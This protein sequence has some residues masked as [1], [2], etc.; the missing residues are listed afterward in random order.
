VGS[1]DP[2]SHSGVH[3]GEQK[4]PTK[5]LDFLF[6]GLQASPVAVFFSFFNFWYGSGSSIFSYGG[7]GFRIPDLDSGFDDL[8]LK[9]IYSRKFN[10]YFLD[11]KLQ[12]T[13]P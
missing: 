4:L 7:S 9:K 10:F 11:Q 2:D 5:L 3:T 8:K 13:Y 6:W 1:L 12:F